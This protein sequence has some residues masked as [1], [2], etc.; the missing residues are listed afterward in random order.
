M[1]D[2][3]VDTD[4]FVDH[5]RGHRA[6]VPGRN[7]IFFST[8][9]RAE[10]FAGRGVEEEPIRVLLSPFGEVDVTRAIAEAGGRLRR[11]LLI[12]LPDALIAATALHGEM[13]LVTRNRRDFDQVR[14]L[15]VRSPA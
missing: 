13:A 11:E 6:F 10:L 2:L 12:S 14:G 9:T 8:I 3:L 1:A 4:V 15:K 5:L 7:R